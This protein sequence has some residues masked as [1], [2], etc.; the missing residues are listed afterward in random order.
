MKK[1]IIPAVTLFIA[2]IIG[3][4][5]L[6]AK[7]EPNS[8]G[9]KINQITNV[10]S[11]SAY[12]NNYNHILSNKEEDS[13][14]YEDMDMVE[15]DIEDEVENEELKKDMKYIFI[16]DSRTVN[17]KNDSKAFPD[18]EFICKEGASYSYMRRIFSNALNKC[19]DDKE[20]IIVSWFGI[21]NV[22]EINKYVNFYNTV[23]LPENVRLVVVSL[24]SGY[25]Y[26]GK[27]INIGDFN[28]IMQDNAENYTYVDITDYV[29][30]G[31]SL[32]V[33]DGSKL[34]YTSNA[35]KVLKVIMDKLISLP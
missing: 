35:D 16:G 32:D 10:Q 4:G 8:N 9:H 20:N 22:G 7:A 27:F 5:F 12:F 34:H 29:G 13:D 15:D 3:I 24:T 26:T 21:N 31:K 23:E 1:L 30:K 19:E 28:G 6:E 18:L 25:D 33:T 11:N 2:F 14:E 17:L